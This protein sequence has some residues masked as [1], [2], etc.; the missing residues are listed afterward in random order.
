[1]T[2]N[3]YSKLEDNILKILTRNIGTY[4]SQFMIYDDLIQD[5]ELDIKNPFEKENFKKKVLTVLRV[6]SDTYNN[7]MVINKNN[8][9]YACFS[10]KENVEYEFTEEDEVIKD[11]T[12]ETSIINSII[13]ENNEDFI[14]KKDYV[15]NTLLHSL[16]L[17][18][19]LNRIKKTFHKLKIMSNEKN[20]NNQTPIE[21]INN[22]KINNFFLNYLFKEN[23]D[24][25]KEK[26]EEIRY[27]KMILYL[28]F[29]IIFIL[30]CVIFYMFC[31]MYLLFKD[32]QILSV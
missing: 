27:I 1:M 23:N 18:N 26:N 15:G 17:N 20:L 32:I 21:I 6:L 25:K 10:E 3:I 9:L 29:M 4:R 19:D 30:S 22:Q 24:F 12:W 28:L 8:I 31:V 16:I 11:N 14:Y 5:L 13:D 2:E 7:I